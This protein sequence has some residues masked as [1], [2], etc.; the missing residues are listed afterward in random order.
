[1]NVK[2]LGDDP[3]I[4]DQ[5]CLPRAKSIKN[6]VAVNIELTAE[7]WRRRYEKEHD[8][9]QKLKVIVQQYE[10][11]L[12]KWRSGETV[13]EKERVHLKLKNVTLSAAADDSPV[14]GASFGSVDTMATTQVTTP[15]T[16]TPSA[17]PTLAHTRAFEEE[18]ARLCQQLDEKVC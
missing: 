16:G 10:V 4:T 2:C 11:E 9:T 12:G 18:R 17:T 3:V 14:H 13:P 15:T 7:E 6:K 8:V 5:Y 1:M